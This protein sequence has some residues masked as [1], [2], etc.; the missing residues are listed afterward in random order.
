MIETLLLKELNQKIKPMAKTKNEFNVSYTKQI[1]ERMLGEDGLK[2]F[3]ADYC[4]ARYG[5][6]SGVYMTE[7]SKFDLKV[8]KLWQQGLTLSEIIQKHPTLKRATADSIIKRTA[9]YILRFQK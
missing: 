3:H 7:P 4:E 9:K 5:E 1:I 8:V 6:R 2:K